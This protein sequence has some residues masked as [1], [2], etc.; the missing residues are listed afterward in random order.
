M[1][2]RLLR[3]YTPRNDGKIEGGEDIVEKT[4][5]ISVFSRQFLLAMT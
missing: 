1:T 2:M 5:A 4:I 3:R